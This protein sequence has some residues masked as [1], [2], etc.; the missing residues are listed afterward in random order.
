[1]RG[2]SISHPNPV[3]YLEPPTGLKVW[4]SRAEKVGLCAFR[5]FAP[6]GLLP[7]VLA[8][9]A[10]GKWGHDLRLLRVFFQVLKISKNLYSPR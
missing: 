7:L 5:I 4:Y 2:I 1:M 9:T 3:A 10:N 6:L 8:T